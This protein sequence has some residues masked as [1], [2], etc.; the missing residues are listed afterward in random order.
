M[1]LDF[2]H[3]PEVTQIFENAGCHELIYIHD[4]FQLVSTTEMKRK[5]SDM[6]SKYLGGRKEDIEAEYRDLG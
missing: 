5:P 2:T 4:K 3:D 6:L 1:S